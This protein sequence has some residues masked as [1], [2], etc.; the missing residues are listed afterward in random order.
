LIGTVYQNAKTGTDEK[1]ANRRIK[2]TNRPSLT[3]KSGK[4]KCLVCRKKIA[5]RLY[6]L[7]V[8]QRC[9][10]EKCSDGPSVFDLLYIDPKGF[11]VENRGFQF[12]ERHYT[13]ISSSEYVDTSKFTGM[14]KFLIR[15]CNEF[16][17]TQG[18]SQAIANCFETGHYDFPIQNFTIKHPS[19]SKK[20]ADSFI[21]ELKQRWINAI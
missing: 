21:R 14:L 6:K 20:V 3:T 7:S 1:M 15:I 12:I 18:Q 19:K 17:F 8:S 2:M 5:T 10:C 11:K 13:P 9:R 4:G 16:G